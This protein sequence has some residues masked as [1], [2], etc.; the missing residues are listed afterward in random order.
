MLVLR[1]TIVQHFV[2]KQSLFVHQGYI[3][4]KFSKNSNIVTL[5]FK[6][7]VFYFM[8]FILEVAK[9]NF[10]SQVSRDPSEIILICCSKK[11]FLLLL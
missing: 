1:I 5:Q 8:S 7:T 9:L 10:Q 6:I 11:H 2:L 4:D 3:C